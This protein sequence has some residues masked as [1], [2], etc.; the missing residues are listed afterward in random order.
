MTENRPHPSTEQPEFTMAINTGAVTP[1]MA[2][3]KQVKRRAACDECS[4]PFN[5]T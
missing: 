4:M 1:V 3:D 5:Q 2:E